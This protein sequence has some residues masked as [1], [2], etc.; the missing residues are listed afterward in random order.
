MTGDAST[1][2]NGQ[3][4]S[5]YDLTKVLTTATP[6]AAVNQ[7]WQRHVAEACHQAVVNEITSA[8]SRS[9]SQIIKVDWRP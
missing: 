2:G 7:A 6:L 3:G 8:A 9:N 5:T 1:P 4:P